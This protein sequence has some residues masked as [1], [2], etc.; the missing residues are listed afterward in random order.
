[1]CQCSKLSYKPKRFYSTGPPEF[2]EMSLYTTV[3]SYAAMRIIITII[4]IV[5][6]AM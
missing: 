2:A 1:M 5:L 3:I 4:M 6:D